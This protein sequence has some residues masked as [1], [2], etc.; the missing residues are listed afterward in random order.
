[1]GG[2][3]RRSLSQWQRQS[4]LK[5]TAVMATASSPTSYRLDNRN[6]TGGTKDSD[7]E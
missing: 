6:Q 2:R 7:E 5:L 4:F 1:M 3:N